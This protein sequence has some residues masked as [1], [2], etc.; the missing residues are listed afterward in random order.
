MPQK[1]GLGQGHGK[2]RHPHARLEI[3]LK[4]NCY[5]PRTTPKGRV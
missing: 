1:P 2:K 5:L 3:R 4:L